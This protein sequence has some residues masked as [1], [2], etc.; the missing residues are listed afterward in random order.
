MNT[1]FQ[2]SA[3][4]TKGAWTSTTPVGE[5][6]RGKKQHKKDLPLIMAMH[7]IPYVATATP[8]FMLDLV[9]KV[10]KAKSIK[11]GLAY[12]HVYNPCPTGWGFLPA[13]S[14]H[15]SREAVKTGLFP[16]YE[17]ENGKFRLNYKEKKSDVKSYLRNMK[18]FAHLSDE[19]IDEIQCKIDEKW[20]RLLYLD[21]LL[22][23]SDGGN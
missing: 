16:L 11:T 22:I 19:E 5:A 18:K 9:R 13:M 1:G 4:T 20:S 17:V 7:D 23:G 21:G 12:I 14:I 8:A 10:E 6:S 2:R 3:S 15:M